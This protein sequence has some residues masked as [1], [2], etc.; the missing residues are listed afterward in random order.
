[1]TRSLFDHILFQAR[2]RPHALAVYG[3]AG[4]VAYQV[5]VHDIDALATELLERNLTRQDMVGIQL[6]FSYLHLVLILAL[7]RLSIPSTSFPAPDALPPVSFM[8][9]SLGVTMII[10]AH[11]APAD[12]PARWIAMAEQH[13]PH[14]G[15]VDAA[16]LRRI[17][18]PA[19]ALLHVSWSSGTT[20]GAKGAPIQRSVQAS[21]FDAR[22]WARALGPRTRYFTG[23]PYSSG[24]GYILP[25]TVLS[26][27]GA[28][29][30]PQ[31]GMDFVSLS[32]TLGVTM[33]DGSPATLVELVGKPGSVPRRLETMEF[34]MV[35]GTQLPSQLAREAKLALTPN[36]WTGYGTTETDGVAHRAATP[37]DPS[38]VGFLFPWVDAEIVDP[39]DRPLPVGQEGL[40][41]LRNAP[42]VAGYYK[43]D[44]ATQRNFRDGWFYPG[45]VGIITE[46]SLLR[47]TGRVEDLIVRD[48]VAI[49]PLPIEEA[50]GG[51]P[52]VRE[53]AVFTMRGAG[54]AQEIWAAVVLEAG[55]DPRAVASAAAARLGDRTVAR[56]FSVDRLPRNANGKVLRR[57]L[58]E[59]AERSGKP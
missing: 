33:T 25:L 12:P 59:W 36:I 52:Q 46:H 16:R 4:P 5:L 58:V 42:M 10:S 14:F 7:D 27:G 8:R 31:P 3:V 30:L 56:L 53:V 22:R 45:D 11:A 13:R 44:A 15:A 39:A 9:G 24:P 34:F 47:I 43:N 51:L 21:R 29:I 57:V 38:A 28:V 48:G 32:N 19:D 35:A 49:S 26:T 1:M 6:G 50:I 18:S 55:S 17:D 23:M 41:R 2:L 40:V 20:G 37:D 54:G